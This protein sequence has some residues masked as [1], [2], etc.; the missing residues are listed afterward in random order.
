MSEDAPP[1]LAAISRWDLPTLRGSVGTLQLVADRL[2]PWLF[3]L[4][5]LGRGLTD[6]AC[7][8][9]PAGSVAGAAVLQLGSAG[10][11]VARAL[12]DSATSLAGVVTAAAE[13]QDCAATAAVTAAS[14]P[15][16]LTDD[17]VLLAPTPTATPLMAPD[18]LASIADQEQ[19]GARAMAWARDALQAAGRA[20]V[21]AAAAGDPLGAAGVTD[22]APVTGYDDVAALVPA[23]P[24][25]SVPVADPA[26]AADWWSGLT[27]AIR[28][29]VI[30]GDPAAVGQ[31]DGLPA[32]A[33]DQANRRSLD[34][35]LA[36]VHAPG[37]TPRASPPT[38]SPGWRP[39]ARRPSWCSSSPPTT[40]W[41]CR[42]ATWTPPVR[43][44]CWCRG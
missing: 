30:A 24:T 28:Q 34:L 11:L 26:Q 25:P 37:T 42:W 20:A 32:W 43:S 35:A 23:G 40:W 27:P 44:G 5:V 38:S 7:W 33:R 19:A 15:V 9:G 17:G 39:P 13:A 2:P 36:D 12:A 41:R 4:D 18:Q 1:G 21:S 16:T 22:A 29:E 31:L 8:S 10:A 3:R 14:G 6:A